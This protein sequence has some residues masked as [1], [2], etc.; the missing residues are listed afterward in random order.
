MNF[1]QFKAIFTIVRI[2]RVDPLN[3][4]ILLA[5]GLQNQSQV[6]GAIV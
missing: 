5:V 2:M 4:P 3:I 6:S 1:F